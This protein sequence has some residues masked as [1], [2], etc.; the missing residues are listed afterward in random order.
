[1]GISG[2][3]L[4]FFSGGA[5][6]IAAKT[7]ASL[8][9][10][11]APTT[12][13]VTVGTIAAE[14]AWPVTFILGALW[15]PALWAKYHPEQVAAVNR[16]AQNPMWIVQH[17][18]GRAPSLWQV[19]NLTG[20]AK[21]N[22]DRH[23]AELDA[24]WQRMQEMIEAFAN[25]Q[26]F[27]EDPLSYFMRLQQQAWQAAMVAMSVE[28]AVG[29]VKMSAGG[30]DVKVGVSQNPDDDPESLSNMIRAI[31]KNVPFLTLHT[32][33]DKSPTPYS[34]FG[35]GNINRLLSGE[36]SYTRLETLYMYLCAALNVTDAL[37][38]E[39]GAG[40]NPD[41]AVSLAKLGAQVIVKDPVEHIERVAEN[42]ERKP[43]VRDRIRYMRDVDV[44]TP[45]DIVFWAD[46]DNSVIPS[47]GMSMG[48]Y[49]GRD[50]KPGGFLVIQTDHVT[51]DDRRSFYLYPP[52]L[53]LEKWEV[54][55]HGQ[56]G[57]DRGHYE[58]LLLPTVQGDHPIIWVQIYR[59]R[60]T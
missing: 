20:Q 24:A 57:P 35:L 2:L 7:V 26:R 54:L 55:Y 37:V 14:V 32:P 18:I 45:A 47:S 30:D 3:K 10:G 46:P 34:A 33:E 36:L 6:E 13:S 39:N 56:M 23:Q 12:A 43:A 22:A 50:V 58:N 29:A 8:E 1:M 16:D 53:D 40:T 52:G 44:S 4:S 51:I 17:S 21:T 38:V 60:K 42:I 11:A 48:E 27:N 25:Q 15:A 5:A 9:V 59:R 19:R 28:A 49:L 31:L 41:L